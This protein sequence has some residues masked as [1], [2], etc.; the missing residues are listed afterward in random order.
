M[1][2]FLLALCLAVLVWDALFLRVPNRLL[3]FALAVQVIYMVVTGQGV[4]GIDVWQSLTGGVIALVLFIP[5]YALRAMG[6]GDVKFFALLGLML[7]AAY[8]IPLWLIAG[9]LAGAH[10]MIFYRYR[11]EVPVIPVWIHSVIQRLRN[12]AACRRILNG[13]QG[14]EGIPYAAYLAVATICTAVY[15]GL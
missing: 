4:G 2:L 9:V 7:G 12:S 3:L 5:L 8:L 14:R 1:N 11:N 13:R 10:A 15:R 6:A